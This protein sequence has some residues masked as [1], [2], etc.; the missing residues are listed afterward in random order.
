MLIYKF[1]NSLFLEQTVPHI[2]V[3]DCP[4]SYRDVH[5]ATADKGVRNNYTA[6]HTLVSRSQIAIFSFYIGLVLFQ[7]NT[8][9]KKQPG[10]ADYPGHTYTY[11]HV[12]FIFH[13]NLRLEPTLVTA[14]IHNTQKPKTI[15]LVNLCQYL[16]LLATIKIIV[17]VIGV[18]CIMIRA[19]LCM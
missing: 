7:P 18:F 5:Y 15:I 10:Y 1:Q 6:S 14:A 17:L 4:V 19:R 3:T 9:R 13:Q 16:D 8:K 11:T 12:K 2:Y